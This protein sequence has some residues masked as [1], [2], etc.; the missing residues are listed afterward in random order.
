MNQ[1]KEE[2]YFVIEKSKGGFYENKFE[3]A[4]GEERI[5][6]NAGCSTDLLGR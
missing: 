6:E 1:G 5:N 4:C 2:P 3:Q